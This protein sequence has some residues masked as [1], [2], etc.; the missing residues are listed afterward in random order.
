MRR[1]ILVSVY[2]LVLSVA[3]AFVAVDGAGGEPFIV[4]R[5][6]DAF[7]QVGI[8][9]TLMVLWVQFACWLLYAAATRR[10]AKPW[11]AVTIWIPVVLFYL[12]QSPVGYVSDIRKFVVEK[13]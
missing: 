5:G 12:W 10:V 3:S 8:A 7:V 13:R 9:I 4:F 11:L 1:N 2:V 6:S